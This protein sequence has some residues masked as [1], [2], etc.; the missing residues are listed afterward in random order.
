[1]RVFLSDEEIDLIDRALTYW[2]DRLHN[3][4][5]SD[6]MSRQAAGILVKARIAELRIKLSRA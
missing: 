4:P 1:M 5:V 2:A 3:A 6:S